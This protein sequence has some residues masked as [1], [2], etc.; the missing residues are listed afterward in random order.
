MFKVCSKCDFEW[1]QKD[2]SECP[3]CINPV[4]DSLPKGEDHFLKQKP[5]DN[6]LWVQALA[7]VILI[8]LIVLWVTAG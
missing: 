4:K 3:V 7:I 2:G 1:H 6:K 8:S 5:T